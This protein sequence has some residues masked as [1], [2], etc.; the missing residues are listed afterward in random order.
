MQ[1]YVFSDTSFERC[2]CW[3]NANEKR[4]YI[5]GPYADMYATATDIIRYDASYKRYGFELAFSRDPYRDFYYDNIARKI[6]DTPLHYGRNYAENRLL[7]PLAA[8]VTYTFSMEIPAMNLSNKKL[9]DYFT[10]PR[11]K[12]IGV[13]FSKDKVFQRGTDLVVKVPQLDFTDWTTTKTDTLEFIKV[14][15]SYTASGGEQYIVIGNFDY[16]KDQKVWADN[17]V[18]G[19]IKLGFVS[20]YV[21]SVSL[22]RDTSIPTI[23][24]HPLDLG[25]DIRICPGDTLTIKAQ[26]YY[27]HYRWNTGDTAQSV[28]ISAPGTYWCTVSY[29]C[30]TISDTIRVLSAIDTFHLPDMLVCQGFSTRVNAPPG[31]KHYLWSTGDT[32]NYMLT[33]KPGTYY[34][35]VSND[36]GAHFTDTFHVKKGKQVY[37]FHISGL[38]LCGGEIRA[39]LDTS[40]GARFLWSTGD[41]ANFVR[42]HNP[43]NYWV[44]AYDACGNGFT[45]SFI[46]LSSQL[47]QYSRDTVICNATGTAMLFVPRG[48]HDILWNTGATDTGIMVKEPGVYT[49]HAFIGCAEYVD[50]IR[51]RFC[52]PHIDSL[53]A[54]TDTICAGDCIHFSAHISNYPDTVYWRFPGALPGN[55]GAVD[56]G[57]V[58]YAAPGTY[59]A[60]VLAGNKGGTDS[61]V[62]MITV[63]AK[64]RL[65]FR[66]TTYTLSYGGSMILF[67]CAAGLYA[68]WY[69][70]DSLI[71]SGCTT[72]QVTGAALREH[73]YCS[74]SNGYCSDSCTY[75][76]QVIDIPHNVWLPNAFSPNNDGRNETFGIITDNPNIEVIAFSIYGRYGERVYYAEH[77]NK[78][79]DGTYMGKPEEVGSYYWQL[80]YKVDGSDET[81]YQ[82]GDVTL[83]R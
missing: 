8:G 26:D 23:T 52:R 73:Y 25:P 67:P 9:V 48:A 80:K 22:V 36:C 33:D 55:T 20:Q 46:V 32:S 34:L 81:Y 14:M 59:P 51:L 64:P 1:G 37:P 56:P 82:K 83:L 68:S 2:S 76:L 30:G 11:A 60:T 24:H 7:E 21:A 79:W 13:Y 10:M 28:R 74:I 43:G 41:T 75:T 70:G 6:I 78:P 50:T 44:T 27:Q 61:A 19:V 71:C 12:N 39:E 4:T 77:S 31:Y 5:T 49:V 65:D 16:F 63:L 57:T 47:L 53:T 66:D 42:L 29:G 15:G 58:C 69:Q 45:D 72:I 62:Y 17:W 40:I 3:I 54:N 18:S 38:R 35:R